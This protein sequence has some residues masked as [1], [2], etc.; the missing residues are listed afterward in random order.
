MN[1][2]FGKTGYLLVIGVF[3]AFAWAVGLW[4]IGAYGMVRIGQSLRGTV[5]ELGPSWSPDGTRVAFASN[6]HGNYDIYVQN[7]DGGDRTNLTNSPEESSQPIWSPDGSRIAYVSKGQRGFDIHVVRPDGS[8]HSNLSNFP[9]LYTDIAWSPDGTKIAF[10]SNRD[11]RRIERLENP[12][13]GPVLLPERRSPDIYVMN[14]DGTDVTRLTFNQATDRRPQWSP[15]GG[16]IMFQ[17]TRDGNSE[18]YVI[19]ADGTALTRLTEND[20]TDIDPAWSPD[21]EQ[22]A[23]AT[24]RAQTEFQSSLKDG[25]SSAPSGLRLGVIWTLATGINFDIYVMNADGSGAINITNSP[26]TNETGP[27]WSPDGS[28]IAFDGAY[29]RVASTAPGRSE[30]YVLGVDGVDGMVPITQPTTPPETHEGPVWSPDGR[31][32][33]YVSR[34]IDSA[35]IRMVQVRTGEPESNGRAD[36]PNRNA[37]TPLT[38]SLS[39]GP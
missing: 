28:F 27:V 6:E 14:A 24:A 23:F 19:D 33:G 30:V 7:A 26:S 12:S 31:H 4:S 17:S 16:R 38:L 10:I 21:G 34:D 20:V 35:R 8:A 2:F 1:Q 15:G 9:S 32:I 18:I 11:V 25:Q 22:I 29:L 36:G 39:K 5:E 13:D 37:G 3:V